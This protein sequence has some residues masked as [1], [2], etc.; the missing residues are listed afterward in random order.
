MAMKSLTDQATEV[1]EKDTEI[2]SKLMWR[3]N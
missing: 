2:L 1:S 3:K